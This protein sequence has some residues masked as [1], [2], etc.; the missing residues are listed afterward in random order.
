MLDQVAQRDTCT[1]GAPRLEGGRGFIPKQPSVQSQALNMRSTLFDLN[2]ARQGR[3]EGCH[4]E[5]AP[6]HLIYGLES[7]R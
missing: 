1:E 4:R 7:M 5:A 2:I 6:R 3:S